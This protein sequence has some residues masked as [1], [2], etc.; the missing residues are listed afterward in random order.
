MGNTGTVDRLGFPSLCAQDGP[1][2]VRYADL[3]TAFP[4]GITTGATFDEEL[5]Y[6]RGL[7]IGTE[8]KAKGV[9]V[10]LGL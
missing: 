1:L 2:G 3:I 5:I 6:Q 10:I 4:A 7:A 9:H 8:S